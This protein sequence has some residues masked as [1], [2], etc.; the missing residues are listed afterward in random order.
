MTVYYPFLSGLCLCLSCS[1]VSNPSVTVYYPFLIRCLLVIVQQLV[2]WPSFFSLEVRVSLTALHY[3]RRQYTVLHCLTLHYAILYSNTPHRATPHCAKLHNTL[4]YS[5]QRCNTVLY[6]MLIILTPLTILFPTLFCC[7]S[8][9][10]YC[11]IKSRQRWCIHQL[12]WKQ[13]RHSMLS[14]ICQR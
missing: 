6:M 8:S 2:E 11:R 1:Y 13:I 12:Q 14:Y 4:C 10:L 9:F 3:T 5:I 7:H